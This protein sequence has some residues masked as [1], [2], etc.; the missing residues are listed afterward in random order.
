M[1]CTTHAS[2]SH[3]TWRTAFAAAPCMTA[4]A[5]GDKPKDAPNTDDT[6]PART[7]VTSLNCRRSKILLTR[8]V[9]PSALSA[10]HRATSRR[11]SRSRKN[12]GRNG[13]STTM[14][15]LPGMARVERARRLANRAPDTVRSALNGG[16]V[17]TFFFHSCD[18][19]SGATATRRRAGDPPVRNLGLSYGLVT[20]HSMARAHVANPRA[21]GALRSWYTAAVRNGVVAPRTEQKAKPLHLNAD[22]LVLAPVAPAPGHARRALRGSGVPSIMRGEW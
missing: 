11:G 8:V 4:Q 7:R 22:R 16:G 15:G 19:A 3:P 13:A 2:P 17:K 18:A 6:R 20:P 9:A 1:S 12:D 10:V 14:C 5:D 21:S